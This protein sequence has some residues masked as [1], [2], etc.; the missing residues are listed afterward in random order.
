M[1]SKLKNIKFVYL[2][3]NSLSLLSLAS[4]SNVN[5]TLPKLEYFRC[6]SCNITEFPR[7][8]RASE[9]LKFLDLSNNSI[10]GRL[11]ESELWHNMIHLDL[12]NNYL[13]SFDQISSMF[14]EYLG[15][16]SNLLRGSLVPLPPTT[17]FISVANN[18][19]T[20]EIPSSFCSFSSILYI[21][22]SYNNFSGMIPQCLASYGELLSL[23]LRMNNFYG[24]I[25]QTFSMCYRLMSL[26]FSDN[27][28]EGP[29]PPSLANCSS[30]QAL[31]VGNNR[32][33]G[34]FPHWLATLPDLHILILRSNRFHGPIDDSKTR[35][36]FTKLRFLDISHNLFTGNL[37][38]TYFENFKAMMGGFMGD[39]ISQ[40]YVTLTYKGRK[41]TYGGILNLITG[42]DL[43]DNQFQGR[44]PDAVGNLCGLNF[45]NFSH[46]N[47]KGNIPSTFR[48]L[49]LLEFLDLSS[50]KL[51]GEIPS[52]LV[53][54]TSL[55]YLNLSHNRLVGPIP[56]GRQFDTFEND[57]YIGNLGLCGR[58]LYI[59]CS[60][61]GHNTWGWFDWKVIMMGYRSGI[62]I[63]LSMG[64]IVFT[65]GKPWWFVSMV[66]RKAIKLN[67]RQKRR[68]RRN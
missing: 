1:F 36:P 21:D 30:L 16:H 20:G 14:L 65:T 6:S 22:L 64:Y 25:P 49:K 12:S 31:D 42:M 66:E 8:L 37:P 15:L 38:T 68:R 55:S 32:M 50:N 43:S 67:G 3:N 23:N 47:L 17:R 51:A 53:N 26:R 5:F 45:L 61:N 10:P 18:K 39:V 13:T 28:L 7:F 52:Q 58:P 9:N 41:N 54:L 62:V 27:Q 35:L 56:Q 63:G 44:I 46:N 29:L 33:E 19:L 59:N 34:S 57:S 48:N 40:D 4:H 24:S 2:S 60:S 11:G